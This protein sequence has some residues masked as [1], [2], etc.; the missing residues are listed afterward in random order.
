MK[1][2]TIAVEHIDANLTGEAIGT[3]RIQHGIP[4]ETTAFLDSIVGTIRQFEKTLDGPFTVE[5]TFGSSGVAVQ[6]ETKS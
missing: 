6:G 5:L 2:I 3:L 4:E 1:I